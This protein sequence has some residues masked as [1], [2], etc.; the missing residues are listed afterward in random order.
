MNIMTSR[1]LRLTMLIVAASIADVGCA[2]KAAMAPP[3]LA[4]APPAA[5]SATR[6][7]PSQPVTPPAPPAPLA[8]ATGLTSDDF[9][10]AP[11]DFKKSDLRDDARAALD[12]DAR[13]LRDHPRVEI[14]IEGHC[15]ERGT[16]EYN[17]ALGERRADAAREY[18]ESSGV[19]AAAIK[20][21]S[22]GK[23]RP[24]CTEHNEACW[25]KNRC[26]HFVVRQGP[27]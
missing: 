5:A 20:T 8:P 22:Y 1:Y 26:A 7:E 4:A 15:D 10:D 13:L 21:I 27:V 12:T 25:G 16:V 23:D 6:S 11:F 17:E 19:S 14:T 18:L 24:F 2:R 9:K 3:T